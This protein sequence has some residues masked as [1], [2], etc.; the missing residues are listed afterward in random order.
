M[1]STAKAALFG[2]MRHAVFEETM[3]VKKF[4]IDDAMVHI[5]NVIHQNAE[6]LL[7]SNVSSREAEEEMLR[8]VPQLQNFAN[9][10]TDFGDDRVPCNSGRGRLAPLE[11]HGTGVPIKFVARSV[12]AVEEPMISPELGLKGN[13]DMLVNALTADGDAKAMFNKTTASIMGVELKTG[14][15]QKTQNA[16]VAQLALYVMMLQTLHSGKG[17]STPSPDSDVAESGLLL[18]MSN[19]AVRA[20]HVAPVLAEIKSLISMRNI[21]AIESARSLRPRGV[22]L[23]YEQDRNDS[24][25]ST[26]K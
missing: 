18:Y 19:E 11:S 10:Y 23:S 14:H 24:M 16:H 8:F 6:G 12:H 26:V 5:R 9:T 4:T 7:S 15:N 2:T 17:T 22:R 20:V 25:K 21:A 13:V 3:K 1:S